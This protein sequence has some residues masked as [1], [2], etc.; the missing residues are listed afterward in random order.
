MSPNEE[1]QFGRDPRILKMQQDASERI[2]SYAKS[3]RR[4]DE[5]E[6]QTYRRLAVEMDPTFV[7]HYRVQ[8]SLYDLL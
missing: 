4:E 3:Q 1:V 5:T 8:E 2:A 6:A 7:E